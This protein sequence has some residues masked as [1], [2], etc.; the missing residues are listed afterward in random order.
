MN[1]VSIALV[2]PYAPAVS[3]F[4][5]PLLRLFREWGLS[6]VV[7]APDWTA[8]LREEIERTTGAQALAYPLERTG[9]SPL[10]D[11]KTLGVLVT[12]LRRLRPGVVVTFQPKPNDGILAAALAR[13]PRRY[14]VVEGLGSA[15]TPGKEGLRQKLVR[16]A[17]G[18]LYYRIS[19]FLAQFK[20]QRPQRVCFHGSGALGK[21]FSSMKA[22]RNLI[23]E[24]FI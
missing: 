7:L 2:V 14:A 4:R 11:L 5:G 8:E 9:V 22:I 6:A 1:S 12:I 15:F 13:V 19:F 20:P 21:G 18:G 23:C 16:A 17:L 3:L 10:A 24:S